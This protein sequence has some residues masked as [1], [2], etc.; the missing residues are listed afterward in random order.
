MKQ[1]ALLSGFLMIF[2]SVSSAWG[3]SDLLAQKRLAVRG[4]H[5][6]QSLERTVGNLRDL[7]SR[8]QPRGDASTRVTSPAVVTGSQARPRLQFALEKCV[9]GICRNVPLR[10][11]LSIRPTNGSC[12][13]NFLLEADLSASGEILT[14]MYDR[15]NVI[16]CFNQTSA[17]EGTLLLNALARQAPTY[18]SG[19]IQRHIFQVIQLQ[20]GPIIQA[21][22]Q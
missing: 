13:K 15:L 11:D 2:L 5:P 17:N 21:L 9:F 3:G 6:E 12:Q 8:F 22:Q 7:F 1:S 10:A 16:I 19:L 20:T 4:S 14:K 18:E